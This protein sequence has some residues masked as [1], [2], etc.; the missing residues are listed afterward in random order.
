[1]NTYQCSMQVHYRGCD[2]MMRLLTSDGNDEHLSCSPL[3]C[4]SYIA[5]R[6][7]AWTNNA[8]SFGSEDTPAKVK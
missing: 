7:K 6:S 5:L 1:M 3:L 8:Q 4:L 2:Q